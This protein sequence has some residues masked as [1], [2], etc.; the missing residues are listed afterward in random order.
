MGK[1][2]I[3]WADVVWNYVTGCDDNPTRRGCQNCY[4]RKIANNRLRGRCG[5]SAEKPFGIVRH[6]KRLGDP[7][8]WR[9][10][11]RVFVTSMGD[12][13]HPGVKYEWQ[14][15]LY[16]VASAFYQHT[17]MFL[18]KRPG[19]MHKSIEQYCSDFKCGVPDN[20]YFG[21]SI[22]GQPEK[23]G[24][25]PDLMKIVTRNRF[26]S[27]EPMLERVNLRSCLFALKW[28]ICGAETGAGARPMNLDWARDLRD[29]CRVAGIPFFF[30]KAGNT[31]E[32]PTDLM[33]REYPQ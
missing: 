20:W 12:L 10:H 21:T 6:N 22:E 2:N 28:V 1:T 3:E 15:Q 8:R 17:Y 9:G 33:I 26:V 14:E 7:A 19:V 30:K 29:Q 4:A 27:V 11:K 5:Y 18:T 16:I 13:Y 25:L 23:N 32:T 24:Y 31:I